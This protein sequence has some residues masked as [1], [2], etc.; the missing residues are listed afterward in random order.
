M[1]GFDNNSSDVTTGT[2]EVWADFKQRIIN[3][4]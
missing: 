4:A 3:R 1:R 2:A